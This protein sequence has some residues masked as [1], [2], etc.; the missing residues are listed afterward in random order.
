MDPFKVELGSMT[1][2]DA[3]LADTA[4][5]IRLV[6]IG[7]ATESIKRVLVGLTEELGIAL[8]PIN[9]VTEVVRLSFDLAGAE[10]NARIAPRFCA[11][12]ASAAKPQ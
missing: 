12:D 7:A 3:R 11:A 1:A 2:D 10:L 8:P 9:F 6:A 4:D 5:L